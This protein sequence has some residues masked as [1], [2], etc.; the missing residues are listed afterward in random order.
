MR[1][2]LRGLTAEFETAFAGRATFV[3]VDGG[4]CDW[5]LYAKGGCHPGCD[6]YGF[7]AAHVA[8]AVLEF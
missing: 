2:A 7:I 8:R 4:E 6:G 5:E 3:A 1:H